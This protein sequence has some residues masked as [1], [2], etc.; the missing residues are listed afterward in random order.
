M[1]Y[2]ILG[3]VLVAY[4]SISSQLNSIKNKLENKSKTKVNL[5]E[6]VGK[7]VKVY[8]D[9]EH[10]IELDGELVSFDKKWLELKEVKKNGN[11]IH[12]K[13]IDKVKSITLKDN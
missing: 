10:D 5:K 9:D 13:R 4:Y 7:K 3:A 11:V 8:L 6:L 12:Y 2:V 1:E